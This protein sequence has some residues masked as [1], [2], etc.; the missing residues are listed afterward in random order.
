MNPNP[1]P[2]SYQVTVPFAPSEAGGRPAVPP[3]GT[4]CCAWGPFSPSP[5]TN[6]TRCPSASTP[7]VTIAELCTNT[8]GPPPS[9]AAKP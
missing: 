6:A 7:P 5:T 3:S 9:G 2:S 1:L 8:S 4:T